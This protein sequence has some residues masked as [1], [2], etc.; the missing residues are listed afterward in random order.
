LF[1]SDLWNNGA[2]NESLANYYWAPLSF[3]ADGAI[4]PI[5]CQN[6]VMVPSAAQQK[7]SNVEAAGYAPGCAI[8][9][10]LHRSQIFR[11]SKTGLLTAL[12]LSAFKSGYPDSALLVSVSE[13][14]S[15][16]AR[17]LYEATIAGS[18]VSWSPKNITVHPNVQVVSGNRYL[19]TIS[20]AASTGCYGLE[21][22]LASKD[23]TDRR[24]LYH[25]AIQ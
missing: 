12:S 11:A 25:F 22:N 4:K 1:G 20:S 21:Y 14:G 18:A 9:K 24:F 8:N 7:I 3:T 23:T 5:I 16:K 17:I 15:A 13:A 19:I 2:K 6:T 10:G